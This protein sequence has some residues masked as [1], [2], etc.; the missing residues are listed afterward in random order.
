MLKIDNR[1]L[2]IYL[3]G[4]SGVGWRTIEKL[5]TYISPLSKVFSMN[6]LELSINTGI[7]YNLAEKIINHIRDEEGIIRFNNN[8]SN[9]ILK[10][11]KII[12]FYDYNYPNS[13][14]EIAQPPWVLYTIGNLELI[15]SFSI[16][17]VGTRNP[18][19]Y[20]K[21]VT[22]MIAKE[23][24]NYNFT[25]VSGMAR[26]IDSIAHQGTLN[27][28]G[29]TIAILGC[30]I[31]IIYPRENKNLYNSIA[32]SGLIISEYPPGEKPHPGFFPQRNRII[33]GLS[34]GTLVIE[35]SISSGSLITAQFSLDQSREV[36]AIPGPITS[37]NSLGT[38]SLIKQ[39]AKL[40]QTVEDIIEEFPYLIL[41]KK[42]TEK[43]DYNISKIEKEIY[44][45][46]EDE[47]IHVNEL[48][49]RTNIELSD[50]YECLLSLQLK[51]IIKQLPGSL[52]V[53][54]INI[55]EIN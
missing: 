25:I 49:Q 31:D 7:E 2:L 51:E 18:T 6:P 40:V 30:G 11:I 16:A 13:L 24:V 8:F 36:F 23:L 15:N 43:V 26:G 17:I 55:E 5:T 22:E 34:N 41:E 39:G 42:Q 52:Y 28:K 46:I 33:S 1:E 35:A 20:G 37:K 10:K 4:L 14:K 50:I 21:L 54:K 53:R 32:Q 3:H 12:T 45:L 38:N 19:N 9:W 44:L 48:Y 27:N 29:K 47:P